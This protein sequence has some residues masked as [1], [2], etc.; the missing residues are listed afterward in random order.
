MHRRCRLRWSI[1]SWKMSCTSSTVRI[2]LGRLRGTLGRVIYLEGLNRIRDETVNKLVEEQTELSKLEA[3]RKKA[4]KTIEDQN[5]ANRE[6]ILLLAKKG[7]MS[8]GGA[9][10]PSKRDSNEVISESNAIAAAKAIII[11]FL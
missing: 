1:L 3:N 11:P 9:L 5:R 6:E 10:T 2:S 4:I 7:Q 8:Y